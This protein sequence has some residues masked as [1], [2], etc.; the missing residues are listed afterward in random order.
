MRERE[1]EKVSEQIIWHVAGLLIDV[2]AEMADPNSE[3]IIT[4]YYLLLR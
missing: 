4:Y 2:T 3:I 1:F